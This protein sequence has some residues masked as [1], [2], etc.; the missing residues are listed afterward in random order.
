MDSSLFL[1]PRKGIHVVLTYAR[2]YKDKPWRICGN[3]SLKGVNK[4]IVF[5]LAGKKSPP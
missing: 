1:P 3:R 5:P 4:F 2:F